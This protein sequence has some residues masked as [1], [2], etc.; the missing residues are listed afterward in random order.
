MHSYELRIPKDRIAVLIGKK[1]S[2]KRELEK[3]TNTKIEVDSDEGRVTISGESIDVFTARGVIQAVARGFNP[4]I[5][6]SL[7]DEENCF[8][9]INIKDYAGKS[10][11]KMTRLKSRIIGSK[12]QAWKNIERL[13]NTAISV[14]GKT[15]CIIGH[16][17]DVLVAREAIENL[18]KGA[19]HGPVYNWLESR[20]K[21]S[22]RWT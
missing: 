21:R 5:A 18:L 22:R 2:T 15:A 7:C 12:G 17:D 19:P 16:V 20:R 3:A 11:K 1:G 10:K 8:E 9:V 4:H 6:C 14:Y 13:T